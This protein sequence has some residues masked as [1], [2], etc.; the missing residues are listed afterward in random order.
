MPPSFPLHQI[1]IFSDAKEFQPITIRQGAMVAD[2][3]VLL[4]GTDVGRCSVLGSGTFAPAG[5]AAPA[6]SIWLGNER[7]GKPKI[8]Q[9]GTSEAETAD[10]L[11]PYG[12]AFSQRQAPYYVWPLWQH[13]MQNVLIHCLRSVL[14]TM[15]FMGTLY[16]GIDVIMKDKL[17]AA[18]AHRYNH[19]LNTETTALLCALAVVFYFFL[20]IIIL[21]ID[22]GG[23]WLIIGRRTPGR[24]N[25]DK[26][27]YNQRWQLHKQ[28][29]G[30]RSG[31]G[32]Y[33]HSIVSFWQGSQYLVWYFR[34]LGAHIG[35]RVCL[36]P[37]GASP[38][39]TEPDLVTIEDMVGVDHASLIA[40][41][42]TKVRSRCSRVLF[43]SDQCSAEL[44]ISLSKT[45]NESDAL[46]SAHSHTIVYVYSHILPPPAHTRRECL[47]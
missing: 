1:S 32:T 5:F 41:I 18:S 45:C 29:Q 34:A 9:E 36:Y 23:K 10:T 16:V 2:R 8:W 44:F 12:R 39:M 19:A 11:T 3:C 35:D 20:T 14:W 25:W 26:S 46:H 47:T 21:C 17:V 24:Y 7:S 6:C 27:S 30:L 38:M 33:G 15:P 28:L 13:I 43:R 4:P 40:H 31:A 22:I 42:N 37:N